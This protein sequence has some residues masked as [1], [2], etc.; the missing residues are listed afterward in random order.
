MAP[1]TAG[2]L[3]LTGN[4]GAAG[5]ILAAMGAANVSARLMTAPWFVRFLARSTAMPQ[6]S[7]PALLNSMSQAASAEADSALQ[8]D[9]S[10]VV[11][12][13]QR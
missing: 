4:V 6:S 3:A 12:Q 9:V 2:A 13:L 10:E 7:V 1:L 5:S 8:A 11:R